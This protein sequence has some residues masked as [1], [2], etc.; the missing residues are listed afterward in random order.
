MDKDRTDQSAQYE[1]ATRRANSVFRNMLV[2]FAIGF[3][4]IALFGYITTHEV[5]V[6]VLFV[7]MYG[8]IVLVGLWGKKR[9]MR[10]MK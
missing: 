10:D 5:A 8:L 9:L 2:I 1:T 6:I 7:V 4:I 3:F